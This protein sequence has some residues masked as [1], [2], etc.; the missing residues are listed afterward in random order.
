MAARPSGRATSLPSGYA[1]TATTIDC[2]LDFRWANFTY[3]ASA[4]SEPSERGECCRYIN[5]LV[6]ISIA[7]YANSTGK[8]GIPSV[9]SDTC[10]ASI[11]ETFGLHGI[12]PSATVFC[13]LGQKIQVS[14]QCGG[15]GTVLEMMESPNFGGVITNCD[16]ALTLENNCRRCLNSG[17]SYLHRLI[18][19][20]NNV[21]LS[22]CR[23][24]V[25]VVLS[26]QNGGVSANALDSCFFGVQ[27]L[28]ILPGM[29]VLKL[30]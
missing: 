25:F 13:G 22:M 30:P 18:G 12:P 9:F 27:G 29:I 17:I 10:L 23:D 14:Y 26:N 5:A 3:A 20:E 24:T 8:L 7:Y 21:A 4:C 16:M 1:T 19:T 6:T 2:P 15:R 11:F 28:R